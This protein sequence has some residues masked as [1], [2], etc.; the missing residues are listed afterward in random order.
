MYLLQI[1]T[2]DKYN[3]LQLITLFYIYVNIRRIYY[4]Y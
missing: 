3:Y 2:K 4:N 1:L